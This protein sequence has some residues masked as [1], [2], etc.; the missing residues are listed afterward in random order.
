[1]NAELI[2]SDDSPIDEDGSQ[3]GLNGMI[4]W[5]EVVGVGVGE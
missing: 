5:G 1:M 2:A 3:A 4:G